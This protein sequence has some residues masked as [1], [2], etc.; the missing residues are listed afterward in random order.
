M[1]D[2]SQTLTKAPNST[3]N[4]RP[5]FAGAEKYGDDCGEECDAEAWEILSA[6]F[7]DVQSVLDRN[8]ALIQQ[9]NENHMSKIPDNLVNNITIIREINGIMLLDLLIFIV[10]CRLFE[11]MIQVDISFLRVSSFRLVDTNQ[12][13]TEVPQTGQIDEESDPSDSRKIRRTDDEGDRAEEDIQ[14]GVLDAV[15]G[16]DGG[17]RGLPML[18]LAQ[19]G[20]LLQRR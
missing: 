4:K 6:G 17:E 16:D 5:R 9:V 3:T 12:T 7:R 13:P 15:E 11:I 1:D 18:R 8:R 10:A 2:T 20:D 14:G 19:C